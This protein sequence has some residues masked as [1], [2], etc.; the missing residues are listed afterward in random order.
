MGKKVSSEHFVLHF[1]LPCL[2]TGNYLNS[3]YSVG[4]ILNKLSC[5][6]MVIPKKWAKS[7]V[8]RSLIKRQCREQFRLFAPHL[9]WGNYVVR[10]KYGFDPTIWISASSCRLKEKVR[11]E[12]RLLFM[13]VQ[14]RK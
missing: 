4:N 14:Q 7:S 2:S 5:L 11:E 3:S 8:R 13:E 6:G 10:L 12:I 9:P 1:H